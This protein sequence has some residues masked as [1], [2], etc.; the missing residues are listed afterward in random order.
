ME[1]E[2][3]AKLEK[4]VAELETRVKHLEYHAHVAESK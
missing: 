4:K 3:L 2:R 1:E